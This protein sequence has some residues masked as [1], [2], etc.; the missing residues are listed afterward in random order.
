VHCDITRPAGYPSL[1]ASH[2]GPEPVGESLD[3]PW[4]GVLGCRRPWTMLW[5]CTSSHPQDLVAIR[6]PA[7]LEAPHKRARSPGDGDHRSV[8][9]EPTN[10]GMPTWRGRSTRPT[11]LSHCSPSNESLR[12]AT[13]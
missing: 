6:L 12:R 9:R 8:F 5:D 2:V 4:R 11:L 13:E 10:W 3:D 1:K 7:E